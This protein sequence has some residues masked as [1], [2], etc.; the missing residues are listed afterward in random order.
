VARKRPKTTLAD[1]RSSTPQSLSPARAQPASRSPLP[2]RRVVVLGAGA[3]VAFGVPTVGRLMYELA[4]FA[5]SEGA[6]IHALLARKIKYLHFAFDK[7]AG[8]RSHDLLTQLF[9]GPS[10]VA[11]VLSA[12][13]EKLKADP[14]LAAVGATIERLCAMAMHNQ[15]SEPYVADLARLAGEVGSVG[16][17]EPVV[18]PRHVALTD[19]VRTAIRRAFQQTFVRG[20]GLT[21]EEREVL[22][23]FVAAT[24]NIEELLSQYFTRYCV[25]GASADRRTYPYLAWML[26]AFLR[27]RSCQPSARGP[28]I[29][30]ALPA[31]GADIVTFNYTTFFERLTPRVHYFH[32]RLDQYLRVDNRELVTNDQALRDATSVASL[33]PFM[34]KLRLEVTR[35]TIDLPAIVPPIAFK[36]VMSREQLRTWADVDDVLH[37]AELVIVVGYSFALAD[38]HFNDLLRKGNPDAHF[39]V[40]N[41]DMPGPAQRLCG[42]LGVPVE[43]LTPTRRGRFEVLTSPRVTAVRAGAEEV[44]TQFLTDVLT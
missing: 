32:G 7:F 28:S 10:E 3:D 11:P 6:P 5:R 26:W 13:A 33:V 22:E 36:P 20:S 27:V 2:S 8:D 39:V 35:S 9:E 40:V 29:Y 14:E 44:D 16:A 23:L 42:I 31:L 1:R 43:R 17:V 41:I 24:S 37:L 12:A 18:D 15:L 30:P 25:V 21:K 4:D 38:E 34:N 19:I